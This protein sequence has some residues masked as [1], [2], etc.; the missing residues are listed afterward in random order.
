[1]KYFF[2]IKIEILQSMVAQGAAIL[3]DPEN[4][5]LTTLFLDQVLLFV[6]YSCSLGLVMMI[7]TYFSIMLF[8]YAA[9]SQ[10]R[11]ELCEVLEY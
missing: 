3:A 5:D 10:V 9:H 7:A 4:G 8:N 11:Q 1:M 2:F 6:I